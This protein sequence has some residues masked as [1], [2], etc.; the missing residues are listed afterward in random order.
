[1]FNG[2]G[3]SHQ[4]ELSDDSLAARKPRPEECKAQE[5]IDSDMR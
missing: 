2:Y 4:T 1:M 5:V 3:I